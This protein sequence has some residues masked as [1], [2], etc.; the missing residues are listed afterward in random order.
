MQR[1][2]FVAML[3]AAAGWP[4]A[5]RAQQPAMPVIGFLGSASPHQWMSRRR[6]FLEGLAATGFVE[7]KNVA[8]E[9]RW[10]E[11]RYE[12]LPALAADLVRRNVAAIVVLGNTLSAL[13]AKEATATIP[14]IFRVAADPVEIGLVTSL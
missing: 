4:L 13:G 9:Y 8:I 5:S 12:R 7:G 14:I 3:G 6:A 10:A 11:G 1:R 2:D